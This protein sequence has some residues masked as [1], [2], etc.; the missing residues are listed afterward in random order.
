MSYVEGGPSERSRTEGRARCRSQRGGFRARRAARASGLGPSGQA[1]SQ[2]KAR[3]LQAR[4]LPS[5]TTAA[6]AQAV[7]RRGAM[8][9]REEERGLSC[10]RHAQPSKH[11]AR[12][13]GKRGRSAARVEAGRRRRRGSRQLRGEASS[14]VRRHG[15]TLRGRSLGAW[16]ARFRQRFV[17][18]QRSKAEC[19]RLRSRLFRPTVLREPESAIGIDLSLRW[20]RS[21]AFSQRKPHLSAHRS[22]LSPL[23]DRAPH[24]P[25]ARTS[26]S[27]RRSPSMT[28]PSSKHILQKGAACS[29]CTSSPARPRAPLA[30]RRKLTPSPPPPPRRQSAQG[31]LR[32]GQACVHSMQEVGTIP[33]RRPEP[34]PV[35]LLCDETVRAGAWLVPAGRRSGQGGQGARTLAHTA[36]RCRDRVVRARL[37][38]P[39]LP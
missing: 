37:V 13:G 23:R 9:S 11:E 20:R 12:S 4:R 33:R 38:E 14:L 24:P 32:C 16:L 17:R 18:E 15:R 39:S 28:A 1:H 34:R 5:S 6:G 27:S 2:G 36:C 8:S 21:A 31:A 29:T 10:A 19:L 3:S 22:P 30:R 7:C 25:S 26:T 35:Q